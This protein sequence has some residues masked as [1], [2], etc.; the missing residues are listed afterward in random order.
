M[1]RPLAPPPPSHPNRAID[2]TVCVII[3]VLAC[4]VYL[5]SVRARQPALTS[6]SPSSYYGLQAEAFRLGQLHL[7][8]TPDPKLLALENPYAGPQGANRPHDMS[9]YDGKFYLYYGAA[10]VVVLYLPWLLLTQT[11]LNEM[12]G[13]VLLLWIGLAAASYWLT[14]LKRRFYPEV[15]PIWLGAMLLTLAFGPPLFFM[16]QNPTFYAVPIAGAFGFLML[17]LVAVDR[18]L[19]ARASGRQA[20][21]LGLASLAWGL[22]VGSRPIYVLGLPILGLIAVAIWWRTGFESRRH[23]AGLRILVAAVLPA[24]LIGVAMLAYNY[25]RFDEP[26]EFGIRYSLA[27]ADIRDLKMV[28]TEFIPKNVDLYLFSDATFVRYFPFFATGDRPFGVLRYVPWLWLALVLPFFAFAPRWTGP[29]WIGGAL[30]SVGSAVANFFLLSLFFGG[31]D[32]YLLDFVPPLFLGACI[33]GLGTLACLRGIKSTWGRR[34]SYMIIALVL[35][36]SFFNG[37]MLGLS[38]HANKDLVR[39]IARALNRPSVALASLLPEQHGPLQ[40]KV[41]FPGDRAGHVEPL[42]T[43]GGIG[44]NGDIV[45][46]TYLD[47][48]QLKLGYF[49]LGI[50]GPSTDPISFD[51]E[52]TYTLT[53]TVG[54]LFPPPEYPG[55][56]DWKSSEI[57]RLRRQLEF[58]LDGK[59]VLRGSA[60]SY[61]SSPGLVHLGYNSIAGDVTESFFSGNILSSEFLGIHRAD[62]PPSA[63]GTGPV[64]LQVVLPRVDESPGLPLISTGTNGAGDLVF[65][66]ITEPGRAVL[67]HDNWGSPAAITQEF[68]F[69]PGEPHTIAIEMGSLYPDDDTTIPPALRDRLRLSFDGRALFDFARPFYPSR[70]DQVEIGYNAINADAATQGFTGRILE[71]E[72]VPAAAFSGDISQSGPL[73]LALRFPRELPT[74][75]EPLVVTGETGRADVVFVKYGADQTIQFGFDHWGIGG[76]TSEPIKIDTTAIHEIEVRMASLYPARA[77]GTNAPAVQTEILLNGEVVFTPP[78][79]AYPANGAP[80]VGVNSIGASSCR[81]RFSGQIMLIERDPS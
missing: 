2:W 52:K 51:P 17:A 62:A 69:E 41:R 5:A 13:M 26:L 50:G 42:L 53:L 78:F 72:R 31:E 54:G 43:T 33:A 32:R 8:I 48:H 34:V 73:R 45:T 19:S 61:P 4:W 11:H 70:S 39:A 9:F 76:A 18:A 38:R 81:E 66:R 68:S 71:A 44:G 58:Q 14:S 36:I 63:P 56:R 23:W 10:P 57:D 3:L 64:R 6:P 77:A 75:A 16:A 59:T 65:V 80:M 24:A 74:G 30:V 37:A 29:R 55:F 25:F 47:N 60:P 35:G 21:W 27:S 46:V 7:P 1:A 67:G 49:H 12:A 79:E 20:V 40:L 28:G 15:S 22:A